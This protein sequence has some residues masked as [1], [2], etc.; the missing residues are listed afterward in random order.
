M[1]STQPNLDTVA[2]FADPVHRFGGRALRYSGP[3]TMR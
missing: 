2:Q 1:T 3:R